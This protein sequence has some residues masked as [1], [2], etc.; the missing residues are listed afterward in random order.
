MKKSILVA[1]ITFL[2]L[3]IKA[4][5]AVH[6]KTLIQKAKLKVAAYIKA[7]ALYPNSY[8]SV[9][10]SD[11]YMQESHDDNSILEPTL[12][13][14]INS[15]IDSLIALKSEYPIYQTVGVHYTILNVFKLKTKSGEMFSYVY[16][17]YLDKNM[18]ILNV[19]KGTPEE[20]IQK[21]EEIIANN[22]IQQCLIKEISDKKIENLKSKL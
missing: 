22:K 15:K 4:Q 9:N 3:S 14:Y 16:S 21:N 7:H 8:L 20:Q 12:D 10:W 17:F 1:L 2:C 18:N 13:L 19:Y 5:N 6:S 11:M